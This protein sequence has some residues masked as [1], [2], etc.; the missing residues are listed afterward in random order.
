MGVVTGLLPGDRD[1]LPFHQ[2]RWIRAPH[3]HGRRGS[4]HVL[5]RGSRRGA[6]H[7]RVPPRPRRWTSGARERGLNPV[8]REGRP[9]WRERLT[10]RA[11]RGRGR[12]P[13]H[14][15]RRRR[16]SARA[17][18]A[19]SRAVA[20]R[21]A[22]Q[23][24]AG[25]RTGPSRRPGRTPRCAPWARP[26]AWRPAWSRRRACSWS[27]WTRLL[28]PA[29]PPWISC[30]FPAHGH[31]RGAGRSHPRRAAGHHGRGGGRLLHA[32]YLAAARRRIPVVIHEANARPS[33]QPGEPGSPAVVAT[34]FP[35]AP[36]R[37]A[38]VVACPCARR[39]PPWTGPPRSPGARGPRTA[40]GPAHRGNRRLLRCPVHEPPWRPWRARCSTSYGC[41]T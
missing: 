1:P 13:R 17:R 26:L 8:V 10:S 3:D 14:Q 31:S 11:G 41:C 19:W 15:T 6:F 38:R 37:G 20:P 12:R 4:G 27:S 25:H 30:A 16:S 32:V 5:R 21:A 34:A 33:R 28:C 40:A 22:D 39:S 23:P 9:T 36:L 24:A 29:G 7:G 2:L 18:P 35:D